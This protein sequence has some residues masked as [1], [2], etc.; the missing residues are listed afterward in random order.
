VSVTDTEL[1][2]TLSLPADWQWL[3]LTYRDQDELL[4]EV[5]AE[6]PYVGQALRPLGEAAGDVTALAIAVG[7]PSVETDQPIPFAIVGR[8][9]R[10]SGLEPQAAL[11]LLAE[12]PLPISD[13]EVNVRLLGQP[14][15]RF[16]TFDLANAFQCRHLF[17]AGRDEDA[18]L[19]A[20]CAPQADYGGL[21]PTLGDILDTFQLLERR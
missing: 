17:V 6:Q 3:D 11:D 8:S 18:Y 2:Y 14:Q 7:G 5:I 4:D 20:A 13:A 10:L 1:R 16:S 9:E 12:Q 21:R 15:A 19:V